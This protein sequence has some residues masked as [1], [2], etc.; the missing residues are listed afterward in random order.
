MSPVLLEIIV[1]LFLILTNGILAMS[2]IALVSAR[3][4]R[5]KQWAEGGDRGAQRALAL[6]SDPSRFFATIQ[7]GITLVGILAGAVGGAT[8]AA[9][10]ADRLAA[11]PGLAPYAQAI[12]MGV[13]VAAITYFTLVL[14]ELAPKRIALID[15]ET[16]AARVAPAMQAL[17]RI[18]APLVGL[19]DASTE[20]VLRVLGL[21][22]AKPAP[23]TDEEIELLLRSG[24]D[25]GVFEPIEE[26]IV[27]HLFRLSDQ[28]VA[29]LITPRTE[30][31]WLDPDEPADEIRRKIME[32]GHSRYP[33]ANGDLDNVIGQVLVKDLM[34]QEWREHTLDV[35]AALQPIP[36]IPET[37]PALA[38][39]D[40]F[41]KD[42]SK[43]A[44]VID[45]FG[46]LLGLVTVNDLVEA[47]VGDLPE[48]G[49]EETV[50][51]VQ[52]DD[53]SWLIDGLFPL[54]EFQ[55]LFGLEDLLAEGERPY[56]TLGGLVMAK[57]DRVPAE[58]DAFEWRGLR[59]E[60][61]D[62]DGCRVDKVLATMVE[63]NGGLTSAPSDATM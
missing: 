18:A 49:E 27:R 5:L 34:A 25:A 4:A 52:R 44:M 60:V 40:H 50:K 6:I 57:L 23:V 29:A 10:L 55:E 38:V 39:L 45:E 28:Q 17:A 47:M 43:L 36:F 14:G 58:G 16:M 24:A 41:R 21:R 7:I 42:R 1:L 62:M 22:D 35:T 9:N 46:G 51:A 59:I 37:V 54:A 33:V 48:I 15:A 56:Q 63:T 61:L 13:V 31:V 8:L 53:G 26:E 30:I 20:G 3:K 11:I 12:G 19:L 2:E 32:S